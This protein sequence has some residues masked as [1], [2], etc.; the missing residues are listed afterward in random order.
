MQQSSP[1]EDPKE[2]VVTGEGIAALLLSDE[3]R[4]L[5][6]SVVA[7]VFCLGV[8]LSG[9]G[10][11]RLNEWYLI[12]VTHRYPNFGPSDSSY[13][14]GSALTY[15]LGGIFASLCAF[16]MLQMR[17]YL[18]RIRE[19]ATFKFGGVDVE[20]R[21]PQAKTTLKRSIK[22]SNCGTRRPG[23]ISSAMLPNLFS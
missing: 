19:A 23:T 7:I 18:H 13:D 14:L 17:R 20:L 5:Y 22:S 9:V 1:V 3:F 21:N 10:V 11:I 15:F 6:F 8:V 4:W 12:H 2:R 16:G